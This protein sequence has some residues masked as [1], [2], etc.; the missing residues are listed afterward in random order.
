MANYQGI[1]RT[2]Y[3]KIKDEERFKEICSDLISE[4]NIIV[5]VSEL[6]GNQYG[7]IG[8]YAPIDYCIEYNDEICEEYDI[9]KFFKQM[10]EII[11]EDDAMILTEVG[12]EKLRY[13]VGSCVIVTANDINWI[14]LE[15][16]AI[17]TTQNMLSNSN[18]STRNSY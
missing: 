16:T 7:F 5:E 12:N 9:T 2:N 11:S 14:D 1:V 17:K 18:W 3:F 13:L 10:Q 4:D 15:S 6:N 8:S